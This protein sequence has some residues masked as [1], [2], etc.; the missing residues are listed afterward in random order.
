MAAAMAMANSVN[1]RPTWPC[2]K[3]IGTNTAINTMVVATTAN[4]TWRVP[5]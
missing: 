1:R 2:M 3:V 5:R 4:P